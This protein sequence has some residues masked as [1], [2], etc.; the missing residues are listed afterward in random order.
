MTI[1]HVTATDAATIT[2]A[3]SS[4]ILDKKLDYQ[5]LVGQA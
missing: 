4:F 2:E 5:K 3:L 1:L